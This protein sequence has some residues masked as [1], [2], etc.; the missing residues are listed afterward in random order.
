[1]ESTL[2]EV[3]TDPDRQ[4][5]KRQNEDVLCLV[6]RKDLDPRLI[7]HFSSQFSLRYIDYNGEKR[8]VAIFGMYDKAIETHR[9]YGFDLV[10]Y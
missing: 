3:T 5:E 7:Y 8:L 10:V 9:T 4:A 6:L 2:L 1:M